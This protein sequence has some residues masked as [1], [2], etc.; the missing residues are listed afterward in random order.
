MSS[1][2]RLALVAAV[3]ATAEDD[4][5]PLLRAL[6]GARRAATERLL[7]PLVERAEATPGGF[8]GELYQALRAA[9]LASVPVRDAASRLRGAGVMEVRGE[10][11]R[12]R[13]AAAEDAAE[14]FNGLRSLFQRAFT[15]R[16]GPAWPWRGRRRRRAPRP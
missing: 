8:D 3:P 9:Q 12:Q 13:T 7:V 11:M 6:V 4:P 1:P 10:G 5:V 16:P 15:A 14:V 2:R